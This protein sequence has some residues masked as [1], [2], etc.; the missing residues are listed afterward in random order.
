MWRENRRFIIIWITTAQHCNKSLIAI[1]CCSN[2]WR[3]SC[4]RGPSILLRPRNGC[5][6]P[7]WINFDQTRTGLRF[8][9]NGRNQRQIFISSV[10]IWHKSDWRGNAWGKLWW[11]LCR[12]LDLSK[13]SSKGCFLQFGRISKWK[14]EFLT[15]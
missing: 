10:R 2:D 7:D 6:S 12:N 14:R 4:A 1:A 3:L 5:W 13:L 15:K 11:K 8:G 9:A